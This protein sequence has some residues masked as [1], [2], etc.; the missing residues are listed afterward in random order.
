VDVGRDL[1]ISP[2]AIRNWV[3]RAE[4]DAGRLEDG[5]L[6]SDERARLVQLE[7]DK[8]RLEKENRIRKATTAY[9]AQDQL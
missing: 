3:R 9:L 4:R 6:T 1:G 8:L 2:Q 7:R 5:E